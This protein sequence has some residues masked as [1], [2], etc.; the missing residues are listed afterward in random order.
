MHSGGWPR[1]A[2][3]NS[4]DLG[5]RPGWPLDLAWFA[6]SAS[7]LCDPALVVASAVL[8]IPLSLRPPGSRW[9]IFILGH[10]LGWWETLS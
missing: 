3:E 9:A 10:P 1:R 7:L 5:S 2:R 8:L 4:S 6:L